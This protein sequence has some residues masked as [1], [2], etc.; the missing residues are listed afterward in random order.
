MIRIADVQVRT[1]IVPLETTTSIARR[2]IRERHYTLV[3]V[4][5]DDGI[6]GIGF[7][8]AGHAGG[9]VVSAFAR[10]LLAPSLIGADA[11]HTE[12]IWQRAYDE[13]L[14]HGRAG[15]GMRALSAIDIALWDRNARA[16][17]LPLYK[18]LGAVDDSVRAYASGGYYLAGKGPDELADELAGYVA[19][20]FTAVKMK[21]G[22]G[23]D[24]ASERA[25]VA[26]ARDRIGPDVELMLDANNA[27]RDVGTALRFVRAFEPFGPTWIEEPFSPDDV[28]SHKLLARQTSV[29]V[30]TGEIEAGRW[31][32]AALLD[33]EAIPVLQA[34]ACVCGGITEFRR[35]AAMAAGA[36]VVLAPH[37]F[38]DLHAHLAASTPNGT[39]LEYF[40]DDAVLNFRRL[41]DTQLEVTAGRA[42]LSDRP[43]LGFGFDPEALETYAGDDWSSLRSVE[44]A[45]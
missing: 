34:D 40:P 44:E 18:Y 9:P 27:W 43:G 38:H 24:V 20:G 33:T 45:A 19:Q 30:A 29:P 32:F 15:S 4:V 17:G 21:V 8:Y 6:A 7:C 10:S 25:R 1:L 23:D 14:L 22:L 12:G 35:V 3:R 28:Q 5:G 16:A 39:W 42:R 37:W 13:T 31:R 26:A 41:I 2:A 11:H 36:G